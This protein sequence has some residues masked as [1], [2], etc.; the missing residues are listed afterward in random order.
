MIWVWVTTSWQSGASTVA[1]VAAGEPPAG[2]AVA[3]VDPST[4]PSPT[5]RA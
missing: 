4:K 3:R 5:A 2:Q 1:V